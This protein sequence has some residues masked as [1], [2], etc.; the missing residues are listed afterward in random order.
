MQVI[1]MFL[2]ITKYKG[3]SLKFL[4]LYFYSFRFVDIG[5]LLELL[6]LFVSSFS[7]LLNSAQFNLLILRC[8]SFLS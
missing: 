8:Y 6:F 1:Y 4:F 7:D 3:K 5:N 2:N